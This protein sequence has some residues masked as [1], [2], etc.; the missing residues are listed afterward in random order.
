MKAIKT[1]ST[2]IDA[3]LAKITLLAAGIRSVVVGIGVSMEGG[4]GGVTLLVPDECIEAALDV[5]ERAES[6]AP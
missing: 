3:E 2:T 6:R 5:L 4:T 1:Y